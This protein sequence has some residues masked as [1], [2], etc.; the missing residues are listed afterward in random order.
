[1]VTFKWLYEKYP[2]E[3]FDVALRYPE[4]KRGVRFWIRVWKE[5]SA[6]N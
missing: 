4:I 1:M 2:E 6:T 5:K 3:T